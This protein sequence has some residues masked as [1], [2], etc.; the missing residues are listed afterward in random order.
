MLLK[1][2]DLKKLSL[3][4]ICK[5]MDI[6]FP[7]AQTPVFDLPHNPIVLPDKD[8]VHVLQTAIKTGAKYIITFNLKDFPS[9]ELSKYGVK[10][11]HPDAFICDLFKRYPYEAMRAFLNQVTSLRKPPKTNDEVLVALKKCQL[12]KTEL[13]IRKHLQNSL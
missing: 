12:P 10:A 3:I 2:P 4:D 13:I 11:L 7:D 1:R 6:A 8:D 5:W 9:D